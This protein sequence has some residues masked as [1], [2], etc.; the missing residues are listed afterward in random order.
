MSKPP[1]DPL[2]ARFS[3]LTEQID[4]RLTNLRDFASVQG[5]AWLA[6]GELQQLTILISELETLL[7]DIKQ[8][9]AEDGF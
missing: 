8:S 6:K 7:E 2:R 4:S 3:E 9:D 1:I 5:N